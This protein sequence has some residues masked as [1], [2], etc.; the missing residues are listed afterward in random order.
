MSHRCNITFN[1]DRTVTGVTQILRRMRGKVGLQLLGTGF[2]LSLVSY[3]GLVLLVIPGIIWTIG[4]L[5][6]DWRDFI[7]GR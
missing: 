2:L 6:K 3:G 7:L 4:R 1:G 5:V